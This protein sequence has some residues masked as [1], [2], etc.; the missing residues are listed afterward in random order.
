MTNILIP[1][2]H[3][4]LTNFQFQYL[5]R[6]IKRGLKDEPDID[7]NPLCIDDLVDKLIFP[8]TSANHSNTRRNPIP[9]TYRAMAIQDFAQGLDAQ[10]YVF[11]IDDVG[12]ISDFG[13]YTITQINHNLDGLFSINPENTVVLCSTPVMEMYKKEGFK[14]LPGELSKIDTNSKN[15]KTSFIYDHKLPWELVEHI[16]SLNQSENWSIDNIFLSEV[17]PSSQKIITTYN[18]GNKIQT[19]FSDD[20]L[21]DD[22]DLTESREYSTYVRQMDEI[23]ELKFNDTIQ[24]IKPGRIGDIGCAVGS[25]IA[26]ACKYQDSTKNLKESDFYGIEASRQLFDFCQQRKENKEFDNPYVFFSKKNAVTNIVFNKNSMNT[27]HT[28]SLTHEIESYGGHDNLLKFIAN[29]YDELTNGG[30]WINRDVIGP[31]NKNK[32]VYMKLNSEDG[33]NINPNQE[34]ESKTDLTNHLKSLSTYYRFI[35]FANDFR[36]SEGYCVNY[37]SIETKEGTLLELSLQDACEFMSKK[38]YIENWQSEMHETFCYW[39]IN[40]WKNELEKQGFQIHPESHSYTN[41]WIVDNRFK[42]KVE[43]F[44]K[45]Q[46]NNYKLMDYP[47]TNAIIVAQKRI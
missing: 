42:G 39:D 28:S 22:G 30:V 14:I 1:G 7:G 32:K 38:D 46:N 26:L 16:A 15:G 31:E 35:R 19:L 45:T 24:Y 25:W 3:H 23:A 47:V 40:E 8:I 20:M 4:L 2:R 10:T 21:G 41:E 33:L 12:T 34:F 6:I 43:L 13:R 29:R 9:A 11:P 44:E 27:I 5:Y 37:N 18:F 36:K 17:H